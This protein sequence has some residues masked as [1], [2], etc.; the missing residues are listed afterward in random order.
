[1]QR[2][3]STDFISARNIFSFTFL[4]ILYGCSSQATNESTAGRIDTNTYSTNPQQAGSTHRYSKPE[5]DL[6]KIYSQAIGDY[7]RIV[8]HDYKLT[9]D[10]LFF[11]KHQY[12]QPDD[13]PDIELPAVIE[14]TNIKLLSPEQGTKKQNENKTSFYINLIGW[15]EPDQADFVFV[16]FSNGMAHQFDG[17]LQY[18]YNISQQAYER[19][20]S[21]FENFL[22]KAK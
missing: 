11:G 20:S 14:K 10:T 21:W 8:N 18:V 15:V 2:K 6:A 13:F 12:G 3:K 19:K 16:T 5:T 9:F 1:M 22:Y 17:H 7:L 4:M